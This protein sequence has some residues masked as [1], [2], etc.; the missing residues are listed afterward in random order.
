MV[1]EEFNV[2]EAIRL[3][4]EAEQKAA[5]FYDGYYFSCGFG[6]GQSTCRV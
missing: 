1:S 4:Q 3:A 5:A 6:A 2:L